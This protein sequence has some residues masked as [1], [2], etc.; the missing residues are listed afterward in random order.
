VKK[1]KAVVLAYCIEIHAEKP[2]SYLSSNRNPVLALVIVAGLMLMTAPVARADLI[3][4]AT[5]VAATQ[6]STGNSFDVFLTDTDPTGSTPFNVGTFAFS[7]SVANSQISLTNVNG[8][9]ATNYIFAGNSFDLINGIPLLNSSVPGQSLQAAD[10]ANVGGTFL[11][12]GSAFLLGEVTFDV[13][14]SAPTGPSTIQFDLTGG[15]TSLSDPNGNVLPFTVEDGSITIANGVATVPV[16][17]S[18]ALA[19]IAGVS[20]G[21]VTCCRRWQR[22]K[23]TKFC[24]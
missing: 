4:S 6:G 18:L 14:A 24:D 13:S 11:S 19:M 12:P 15:A 16:P 8:L 10:T 2:M 17:G 3:I 1:C 22:W 5:N 20:V 7:V 23:S 21:V 9:S